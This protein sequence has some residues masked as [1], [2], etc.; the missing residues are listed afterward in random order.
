MDHFHKLENWQIP[1]TTSEVFFRRIARNKIKGIREISSKAYSRGLEIE[2]NHYLQHGVKK[3]FFFLFFLF[4]FHRS[5]IFLPLTEVNCHN[6]KNP[7]G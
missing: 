3:R 4:I 5:L 6:I 2:D 7:S 1:G